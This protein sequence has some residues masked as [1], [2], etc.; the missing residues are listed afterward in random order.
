MIEAMG[1]P[2]SHSHHDKALK[3]FSDRAGLISILSAFSGQWRHFQS[4]GKRLLRPV[5]D[6]LVPAY[7]PVSGEI[8]DQAGMLSGKG[9]V[10]LHFIEPPFCSR[11]SLPFAIEHGEGILCA[12]CLTDAHDFNKARCAVVYDDCSRPLIISFK[13]RDSTDLAPLLARWLVR[14][15]RSLLR[16][17]SILVPVPLH[18]DRIIARRFNQSALLAKEMAK[19]T[20]A[21]LCLDG[22]ERHR[23][24]IPQK[25]LSASGRRRNVSGAFAIKPEFKEQFK[26]RH[27]IL[28]DDVMTTGATLSA[29]ARPFL[30]N[31][32]DCVDALVV[33]RVVNGVRQAI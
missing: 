22:I 11:C 15:S 2:Q 5:I 8:V 12:H 6:Q 1:L 10:R 33:A 32:A 17:E 31:G 27:V 7:C 4:G 28:I 24:T 9:W 26:G 23:A 19:L 20:Q 13:H 30:A 18:R 25:G 21:N 3:R 16:P 29:C 14:V